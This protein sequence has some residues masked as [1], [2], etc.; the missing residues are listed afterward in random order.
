MKR[1][2]VEDLL[3]PH[4]LRNHGY[5]RWVGS[6]S[7]CRSEASTSSKPFWM[8]WKP[9]AR[10]HD[11]LTPS[12]SR[13]WS[14]MADFLGDPCGRFHRSGRRNGWKLYK[15][16]RRPSWDGF[17]ALEVTESIDYTT[18][19]VDET[20]TVNKKIRKGRAIFLLRQ[21]DRRPT[22]P[23]IDL[24]FAEAGDPGVMY[25]LLVRVFL[26]KSS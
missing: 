5:V 21:C 20:M 14:K 23:L 12:S 22:S 17:E 11:E 2:I 10:S 24:E 7:H 4:P 13:S 1:Y 18:T 25:H 16:I 9:R 19:L 8:W 15:L 26:E 6:R 3:V